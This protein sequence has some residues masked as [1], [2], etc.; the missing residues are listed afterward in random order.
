M[1][2]KLTKPIRRRILIGHLE[3]VV[4][5]LPET[6]DCRFPRIEF[7]AKRARKVRYWLPLEAALHDAARRWAEAD[8]QERAPLRKRGKS[9]L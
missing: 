2:T 9:C 7:R 6:E 3:Y 5:L 8:R 4:S 1:S